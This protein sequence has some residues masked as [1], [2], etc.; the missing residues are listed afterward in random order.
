MPKNKFQDFI[1]TIIMVFVMVYAMVVYNISIDKG[2]VQNECFLLAFHELPIMIP[3]GFIL[4][5]LLVGKLAQKIVFRHMTPGKD[6]PIFITFFISA[7]TVAIMCPLMSFFACILFQGVDSNFF[8]NYIGL[9]GRN[10]P[11]AFFW[12]MM[13]AGPLVRCIFGLIFREKES[14]SVLIQQ[15]S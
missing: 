8:G 4:E 9:W 6:K 1:F 7:V 15:H 12:Q 14:A 11:V 5:F 2:G 13:Y 3:I 10:L